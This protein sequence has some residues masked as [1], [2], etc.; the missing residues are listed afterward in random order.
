MGWN[1]RIFFTCIALALALLSA[2]ASKAD[3]FTNGQ[4]IE[5]DQGDWAENGVASSLLA[6]DYN[7]V[8]ASTNGIFIV[9]SESPGQFALAFTSADA[10]FQYLPTAGTP[11]PLNASALNPTTD[12][13]G[14]FGGYVA[15]LALSVDFNNAGYLNGN[16][17]TPLGG[18][19]LTNLTGDL[20]EFNGLTV[21]Q[22]LAI[23]NI[24]LGDGSCPDGIPNVLEITVQV[25]ESFDQGVVSSFADD[26]LA[27]PSSTTTS[28]MPEPSST[29]L[30][31]LGLLGILGLI[32]LRIRS[33]NPGGSQ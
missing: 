29:A 22:L 23:A 11:A 26:H 1:K 15:A 12:S 25:N 14:V 18:L 17:N 4:F 6:A 27:M 9:G 7:S 13:S 3:N 2:G 24:C 10:L 21:N 30:L 33:P 20:S 5:Y 8:F 16:S 31:G 19:V 28:P 32:K